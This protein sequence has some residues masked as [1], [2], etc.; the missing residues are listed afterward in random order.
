D[1]HS[2]YTVTGETVNLASRLAN[3]AEAGEILVSDSLWQGL[4]HSL[5][6][7]PAGELAIDGFSTPQRAWHVTGWHGPQF[8]TPLIGRQLELHQCRSVLEACQRSGRG[9]TILLRGEAGMGK[10]RL[11]DE[12]LM[13]AR[14]SGYRCHTGLVLDFGTGTARGAIPSLIGS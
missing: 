4:A 11:L 9:S 5:E 6:G 14:G 7:K 2:E 3:A 13:S 10:T 1:I 12:V 8:A